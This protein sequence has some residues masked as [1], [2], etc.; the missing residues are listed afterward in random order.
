MREADDARVRHDEAR[1]SC[2]VQRAVRKVTRDAPNLLDG[3]RAGSGDDEQHRARPTRDAPEPGLE[4]R[5]QRFGHGERLA[6]AG[7]RRKALKRAAQLD[8]VKRISMRH[9]V[10]AGKRPAGQRQL[11]ALQE[12]QVQGAQAEWLE[13]CPLGRDDLVQTQWR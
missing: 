11:Q 2:L 3:W 9:G 5:P 7:E 1:V 4:Q 12:Q 8:R 10:D 6:G 13:P